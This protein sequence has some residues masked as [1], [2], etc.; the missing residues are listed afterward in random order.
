M[1]V[2]GRV[3]SSFETQ[4]LATASWVALINPPYSARVRKQLDWSDASPT[5]NSRSTLPVRADQGNRRSLRTECERT[6]IGSISWPQPERLTRICQL[7]HSV[8]RAHN[9]RYPFHVLLLCSCV[10]S[11]FSL[12]ITFLG[13]ENSDHGVSEPSYQ[14]SVCGHSTTQASTT[15]KAQL[16]QMYPLSEIKGQGSDIFTYCLKC[17]CSHML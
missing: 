8:R 15:R 3:L 14:R 4:A 16:P 7:S 9:W 17:L 1:V 13:C 6:L 11:N 10:T 12:E 5:L 2:T